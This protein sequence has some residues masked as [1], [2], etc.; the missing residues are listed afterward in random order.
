MT[1]LRSGAG[2]AQPAGA[3]RAEPQPA[4]AA[5]AEPRLLAQWLRTGR[6]TDL[7]EH[8]ARYHLLPTDDGRQIVETV[9]AA[10]LRGR[11]GAWFPT[12]R[13]LAAVAEHGARAGI[14]YVVANAAES[15]PASTKD[16]LLLQTV[17]HLVL[18]GA[19][20]AAAAVGATAVTVCVHREA[21]AV[22][23]AQAA[24]RERR[25]AGWGRPGVRV[26]VVTTPRRYVSAEATALARYVGGEPAK[27]RVI[28][29]YRNGVR[30]KPTLVCN[31]ETF[32]H[33][34][35]I[36]RYGAAW[37][38]QT[39]TAETPGTWLVTL[40]G[41]VVRPGVYEVPTG[42]SAAD[43]VRLAGGPTEPWRAMLFGGYCGGWLAPDRLD[44]PL[45]PEQLRAAG[46]SPGAGVLVGLPEN[47]CGLAE[48]ARA[49]GWLATQHANQCGPCINGTPAIADE[50]AALTW[51]GDGQALQRLRFTMALIHRRGACA[52]PDG[53]ASLTE[54]ALRVFADDVRAHITAGGCA[55]MSRT[56]TLPIPPPLPANEPWR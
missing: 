36:A 15:E 44:V 20:L 9:A 14:A 42:F 5:H 39:G 8:A 54:S 30:G 28:S 51:R 33:I 31:A 3:V 12:G 23:E 50:L 19:E 4:G 45:A 11:G 21:H 49:V 10:G 52:H 26:T 25:A 34:A 29:A 7:A 55:W 38:R 56:P 6:P 46:L 24:V 41:A 47:A 1:T 40:A 13:K 18:D 53:V 43:I 48:T 35:L 27:P 37:F 32:A 2:E 22:A 17:P 16:R